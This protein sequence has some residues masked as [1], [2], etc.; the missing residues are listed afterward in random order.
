MLWLN[1]TKVDLD[2]SKNESDR[3]VQLNNS[4]EI[5]KNREQWEQ[6]YI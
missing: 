3:A 5:R 1:I 4:A 6:D 2:S